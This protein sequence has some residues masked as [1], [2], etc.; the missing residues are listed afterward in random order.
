M[1]EAA[2][3]RRFGL[4]FT[5]SGIMRP[6][7]LSMRHFPKK[8]LRRKVSLPR[9][10]DTLLAFIAMVLM[11]TLFE[12]FS[13]WESEAE[14]GADEV[15]Y[16][17][18]ADAQDGEAFVLSAPVAKAGPPVRFLMYNVQ[19]YF[20]K[21]ERQ[22]SRY[23]I[24]PKKQEACEAVA[25]TIA[26]AK[27]EIV[28]LVEIGGPRALD[29]LAARLAERGLEYPHRKVLAREGE[30]RALAILSQ[31]PIVRD[32]SKA[33]YGLMGTH[34]RKMLRGILDVTV[35]VKDKRMFRIIG[36]HLK[37]HKGNSEAAT[38]A[39]RTQEARTLAFYVSQIAKQ[40]SKMPLLVYGDWNDGPADDSVRILSQGF[41]KQGA[42]RCLRPV[43]D[44]GDAWTHYYREGGEYLIYDRIYV[45]SVLSSRMGRKGKSGIEKSRSGSSDHRAVWCDLY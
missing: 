17:T 7:C 18:D 21:G 22:R 19:N 9:R 6:V 23:T 40:E 32:A 8:Q 37:S 41:S 31:H 36:A 4:N 14:S 45:N 12:R 29:D 2:A 1:A 38:T 35:K 28:G 24:Y 44:N 11:L 3:C 25:D 16:T 39:L 34:N 10:A 26:A 13:S 20:V 33:E 27:P 30:D 43:D 5:S 15:A 42:L